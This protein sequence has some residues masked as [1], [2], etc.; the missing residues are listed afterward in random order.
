MASSYE[1][2]KGYMRPVTPTDSPISIPAEVLEAHTNLSTRRK[3]TSILRRKATTDLSFKVGDLVEVF[4]KQ[5]I[6]KQ[7]KW[8][9]PKLV[10]SV[11]PKTQKEVVPGRK[12]W[13]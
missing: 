13:T 2:A 1:T 5:P 10:L 6:K 4:A 7:G 9:L 11:N 3:L 12:E 8:S